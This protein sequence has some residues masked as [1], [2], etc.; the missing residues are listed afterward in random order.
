VFLKPWKKEWESRKSEWDFL[1]IEDVT[2]L[3]PKNC[4]NS[5]PS[6]GSLLERVYPES[7]ARKSDTTERCSS[8][9]Q[10]LSKTKKKNPDDEEPDD[11]NK[12]CIWK[13]NGQPE[14]IDQAV[15]GEYCF[16][17]GKM[18]EYQVRYK[19]Q[20]GETAEESKKRK[21]NLHKVCCLS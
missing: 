17:H 7:K 3:E 5:A 16:K 4:T 2:D 18:K 1:F 6:D 20:N 8:K 21:T 15:Y 13:E 14:C 19:E 10:K 12:M 11:E 9:R